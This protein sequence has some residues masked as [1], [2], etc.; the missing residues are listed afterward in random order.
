M[1]ID[2]HRAGVPLSDGSY[3]ATGFILASI[4]RG[5]ILSAR[6][7]EIGYASDV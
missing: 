1:E 6:A 5:L 2:I 7:E 3:D 4:A